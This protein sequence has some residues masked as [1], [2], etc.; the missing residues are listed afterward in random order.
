LA[1]EILF[2]YHSTSVDNEAGVASGW[3]D[4]PLSAKGHERARE[5]G[6]RRS[7]EQIDA[8]FCSDLR[9]AVETAEIAFPNVTRY[10]DR[11]LREYDYG[12]MTGMPTEVMHSERPLRVETP[13]PEGESLRDVADRVR[14][15]LG[16]VARRW[17]GKRL[18]I[19][20]HGATRL[21]LEHLLGGMS[22]EEAASTPFTWEP[23][24]PSWRFVLE[25]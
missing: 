15:F 4:P 24:P 10:K 1:V 23:V 14:G 19:I 13:F 17:D 25:G 9:R 12:T 20:G 18:V 7:G 8:V 16:D 21:A 6:E 5:L 3:R 22:L 2:E 11:R